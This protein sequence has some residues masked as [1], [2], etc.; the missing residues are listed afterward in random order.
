MAARAGMAALA[1]VDQPG[2]LRRCLELVIFA[3]GLGCV[4]F[5]GLPDKG[6]QFGRSWSSAVSF[7]GAMGFAK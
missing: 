3:L 5:L 4:A 6:S 1:P 2:S 7:S